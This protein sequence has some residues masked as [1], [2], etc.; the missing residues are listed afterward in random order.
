MYNAIPIYPVPSIYITYF[1]VSS[2]SHQVHFT[3]RQLYNLTQTVSFVHLELCYVVLTDNYDHHLEL[4]YVA[5]TDNY[6]HHLELCYVALTDN[7]DQ[8]FTVK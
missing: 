5:L 7:Y 8:I 3:S 6:D 1:V 4:C 2:S